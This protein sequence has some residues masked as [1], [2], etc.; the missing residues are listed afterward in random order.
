[1]KYYVF[2]TSTYTHNSI[3]KL[4]HITIVYYEVSKYRIRIILK[5]KLHAYTKFMNKY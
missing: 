3:F 5:I 1:M 4:N 2:D